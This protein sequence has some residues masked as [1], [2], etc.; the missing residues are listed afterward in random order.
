MRLRHETEFHR[1]ICLLNKTPLPAH[2]SQSDAVRQRMRK[3]LADYVSLGIA[4][5]AMYDP[6]H[7]KRIC[8]GADAA[9]IPP[10]SSAKPQSVE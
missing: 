1:D 8:R 6:V 3:R 9:I 7:A 10:A 5:L 4:Q 2:H